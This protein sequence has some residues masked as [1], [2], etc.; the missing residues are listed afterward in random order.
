MVLML[1]LNAIT[2]LDTAGAQRKM[3]RLSL[4]Q[5][6]VAENYQIALKK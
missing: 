6:L 1:R 3:G 5:K 2:Q 4:E